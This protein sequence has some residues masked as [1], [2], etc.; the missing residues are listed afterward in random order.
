MSFNLTL[1]NINNE[2][3][4][5][6][7]Q[8]FESHGWEWKYEVV[9]SQVT[10]CAADSVDNN[11][12]VSVNDISSDMTVAPDV[13]GHGS[14][15]TLASASYRFPVV[16]GAV[17]Y[18]S[19]ACVSVSEPELY[20]DV[21]NQ[22]S[23]RC[24]FCFCEPCVTLSRQKWLGNGQSA[25]IRN[26]GLRRKMYRQFW[27]MLN[28][29]NAWRHPLY[30]Q[31]KSATMGHDGVDETVVRVLREIMPDCVLSLVR[32]LYPNPPGKPYMGHKWW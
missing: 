6:I 7:R 20:K 3:K 29:R 4:E 2:K 14:C 17:C 13:S 16:T 5:V 26:S 23:S 27:N 10:A 1:L 12:S 15:D 21:V 30:L 31:N 28:S 25:H 8:L 11:S 18:T 19:G 22:S 9:P 24:P 32:D